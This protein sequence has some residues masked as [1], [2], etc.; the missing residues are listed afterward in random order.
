MARSS[1]GIVISQRKYVLDLLKETGLLGCKPVTTPIDPNQKLEKEDGAKAV[2]KN[3]YQK[4]VGKLIYLAHTRPD[5]AFAV[6]LVSQFM[7]CP[8][9]IHSKDV[10][11]ILH[12]L[13]GSPGKGIMFSKNGSR[14]VEIFT[15]ADWGGSSTDMRSTT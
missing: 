6:S 2:D 15:D 3:R 14:R 13:K 12:Y 9:E 1:K 4:L 7:H 10:Y 11:R 5:I 8:S